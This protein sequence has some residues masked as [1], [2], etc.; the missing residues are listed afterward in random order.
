MFARFI[1]IA[2]CLLVFQFLT[3][4]NKAPE[5]N[6]QPGCKYVFENRVDER[7]P[8]PERV[9][10]VMVLLSATGRN[11]S[12]CAALFCKV[13][14][15]KAIESTTISWMPASK[16]MTSGW[17]TNN[18]IEDGINLDIPGTVA[19]ANSKSYT[20]ERHGPYYI[21]EELCYNNEA[22]LLR[23]FDLASVRRLD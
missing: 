5:C 9:D 17:R 11:D 1:T 22:E 15:E 20:I 12:H 7:P 6:K 14:N 19:W 21:K 18:V 8:A 2:A 4:C 3:G 23:E 10:H 13:K 16:R